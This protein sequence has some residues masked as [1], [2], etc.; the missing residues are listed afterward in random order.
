MVYSSKGI[1]AMIMPA[2][3]GIIADKRLRAER[4]YMP[5]TWCVRAYFFMRHP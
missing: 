3:M 2:I 4:A 5:F 1:A